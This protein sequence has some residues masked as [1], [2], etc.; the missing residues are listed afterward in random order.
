[1]ARCQVCAHA[2]RASQMV[3]SNGFVRLCLFDNTSLHVATNEHSR[4]HEWQVH[5]AC[6]ARMHWACLL[7]TTWIILFTVYCHTTALLLGNAKHLICCCCCC[8]CWLAH[9]CMS[10]RITCPDVRAAFVAGH[11]CC[12]LIIDSLCAFAGHL[13][14]LSQAV[15]VSGCWNRPCVH[16][17][18]RLRLSD[19]SSLSVLTTLSKKE[20]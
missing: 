12:V 14:C 5:L 7:R 13:L 10:M 19:W 11:A 15:V 18:R 1:M 17:C 2:H 3:G 9:R 8:C 6:H 16:L 4:A 20:L